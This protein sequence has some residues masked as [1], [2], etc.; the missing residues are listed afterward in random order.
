MKTIKLLILTIAIIFA[1]CA[2]KPNVTPTAK[3]IPSPVVTTGSSRILLV[4]MYAEPFNTGTVSVTNSWNANCYYQ[5][6]SNPK[7]YPTLLSGSYQMIMDTINVNVGDILTMYWTAPYVDSL[8]LEVGSMTQSTCSSPNYN[9]SSNWYVPQNNNNIG[10]V[11]NY[12]PG[13]WTEDP[14]PGNPTW[15]KF[16]YTVKS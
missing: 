11:G 12:L 6:N 5:I 4:S 16:V 3:T 7:R 10:A 2:K 13:L 1:S 9:I 14:G 15:S 8:V